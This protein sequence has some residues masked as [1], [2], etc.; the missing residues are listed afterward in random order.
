VLAAV[1]AGPPPASRAN[2]AGG[3]V[4]DPTALIDSR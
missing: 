3:P 4:P 2:S 1:Q